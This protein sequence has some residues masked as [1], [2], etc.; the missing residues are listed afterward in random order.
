MDRITT[1]VAL[2]TALKRCDR[3]D[4]VD[5]M[6]M[7]S[8][9]LSTFTTMIKDIEDLS[10]VSK[11][12][13]NDFI[14]THLTDEKIEKINGLI[15]PKLWELKASLKKILEN[16]EWKEGEA[17]AVRR[18]PP[19]SLQSGKAVAAERVAPPPRPPRSRVQAAPGRTNSSGATEDDACAARN[20]APP[21]LPPRRVVA[22]RED[23]E[24]FRGELW[25][26]GATGRNAVAPTSELQTILENAIPE[27][28]L[29]KKNGDKFKISKT[30]GT[31]HP[32]V[33]DTKQV[34]F[35]E[36]LLQIKSLHIRCLIEDPIYEEVK[37]E[38]TVERQAQASG[39]VY[40]K[41][42][43]T[44]NHKDMVL[45]KTYLINQIVE[46]KYSK[47]ELKFTN[48]LNF[49][50]T[51][52]QTS[53]RIVYENGEFKSDAAAAQA[54][55]RHPQA[56]SGDL[57]F[58]EAFNEFVKQLK[59]DSEDLYG[60]VVNR[61]GIAPK[62]LYAAVGG[63]ESPYATVIDVDTRPMHPLPQESATYLSR[64]AQQRQSRDDLYEQLV[65]T[66]PEGIQQVELPL[67]R[68]G[69]VR[70]LP[71]SGNPK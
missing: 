54:S 14:D 35:S 20:G 48:L 49:T 23:L 61:D 27:G 52:K 65:N 2:Q 16:T 39:D 9:T 58:V 8:T 29:V 10:Q 55:S 37:H 60:V 51:N 33:I 42:I 69:S 3:P 7:K 59:K 44:T 13:L 1:K 43:K 26:M 57:P 68:Q 15:R 53:E 71:E 70:R 28:Y 17:A 5:S 67:G 31:R 47:Y 22:P 21:K 63:E 11:R 6:T 36:E 25:K 45:L 18:D 30:D 12:K 66:A 50:L 38:N 62:G 34:N 41:P 24:Q 32:I 56:S 19:P 40:A 46:E 64:E 4:A